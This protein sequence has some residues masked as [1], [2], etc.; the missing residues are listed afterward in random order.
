MIVAARKLAD[1]K[2]SIQCSLGRRD[3]GLLVF[4]PVALTAEQ[5][6]EIGRRLRALS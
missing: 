2:P 4:N 5:A 6:A 3:E 1:G